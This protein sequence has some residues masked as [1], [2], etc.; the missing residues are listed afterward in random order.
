MAFSINLGSVDSTGV[1]SGVEFGVVEPSGFLVFHQ[2]FN[3]TV[4]TF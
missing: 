3:L 4:E 2:S 1:F